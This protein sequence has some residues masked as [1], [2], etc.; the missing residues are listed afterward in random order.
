MAHVWPCARPRRGEIS[1]G[2]RERWAVRP[3]RE[4]LWDAALAGADGGAR[5]PEEPLH[6]RDVDVP[7]LLLGREVVERVGLEDL[8]VATDQRRGDVGGV[9][10]AAVHAAV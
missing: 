9:V 10:V 7:E 5:H 2:C 6:D 8:A 1:P 3:L 4:Q